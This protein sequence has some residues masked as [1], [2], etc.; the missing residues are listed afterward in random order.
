M[1]ET[2]ETK[3]CTQCKE[4]K[5]L[6]DFYARQTMCKACNKIRYGYKNYRKPLNAIPKDQRVHKGKAVAERLKAEDP[7]Y[8][9]KMGQ[10]GGSTPKTKPSGFA[11]MTR[12]QRIEAGRKGG[13]AGG[14]G[15]AVSKRIER[16]D[17]S[18]ILTV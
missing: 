18:D 11:A 3:Q 7:D 14:R 6:D 8:F 13:A 16:P 12:E 2:T 17:R 4:T 10:K 5:A 1:S 9:R 15:K